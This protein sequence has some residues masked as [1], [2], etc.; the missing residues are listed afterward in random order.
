MNGLTEAVAGWARLLI[1]TEPDRETPP[2]KMAGRDFKPNN[3]VMET[4]ELAALI[5]IFGC[6][7]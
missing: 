6:A 4:G 2:Y 3:T 5:P 1:S 7:L